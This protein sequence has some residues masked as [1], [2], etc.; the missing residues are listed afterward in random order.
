[1]SKRRCVN[2][3][4]KFHHQ[5]HIVNQRYC[6]KKECQNARKG[7]WARH[8]LKHDKSYQNYR[9]EVQNKWKA[10]NPQYWARYKEDII[11]KAKN[12]KEI[13]REKT[14]KIKSKKPIL[15][16]LVEKNTLAN[17]H[18]MRVINCGCKLILIS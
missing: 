7:K 17:L 14:S 13:I 3:K 10:K 1:M 18:K 15:K 5:N 11:E 12:N 2:C 8:K 6:S 4:C 9:K 16:I